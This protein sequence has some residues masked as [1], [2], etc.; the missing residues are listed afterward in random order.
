MEYGDED[1][2]YILECAGADKN[3][4]FTTH[5]TYP[6]NLMAK[7]ALACAELTGTDSDIFLDF[8]GRCFVR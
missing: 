1:W 6:D 5:A 7:I 8:F 3:L 2:L 4:V